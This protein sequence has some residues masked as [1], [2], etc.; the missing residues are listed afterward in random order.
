MRVQAGRFKF[1]C[2]LSWVF[3]VLALSPSWAGAPQKIDFVH[4]IAP[5]LKARCAECHTN[6]KFKGN[7][8]LETREDLIKM[9]A[10]TPG[11][12]AASTLFE[13]YHQHR[14]RHAHAAQGE[15]ADGQGDRAHQDM[16]R[17]GIVV[18]ARFHVQ[19]QHL[20]RA[21]QA[22]P[23]DAPAGAAGVGA[24]DRQDPRCILRQEQ[25]HT[26]G[27]ARRCRVLSAGI[28]GPDRVVAG[29]GGNRGVSQGYRSGQAPAP[30]PAAFA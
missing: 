15:S 30:G 14:S 12:S 18:G 21:D 10:A 3:S 2:L 4:E 26:P 5:I 27:P 20:C 28:S 25:D 11:K 23:T 17:S 9:K 13:A 7:I 19:D 8:S 22:A 24:S 1:L 29:A 6:G 16:D